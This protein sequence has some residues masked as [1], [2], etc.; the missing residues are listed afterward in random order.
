MTRADN[1]LQ[2]SL[3]WLHLRRHS[4]KGCGTGHLSLRSLDIQLSQARDP[5]HDMHAASAGLIV[6]YLVDKYG[7][8]RLAPE[9][10]SAQ[11]LQYTYWLHYSEGSAMTPILFALFARK[12]ATQSPWFLRPIMSFIS[13]TIMSS[14]VTGGESPASSVQPQILTPWLGLL[15]KAP[16]AWL[17]AECCM[18]FH[19]AG[20]VLVFWTCGKPDSAQPSFNDCAF[21]DCLDH[22]YHTNT[23]VISGV[24]TPH[25][26]CWL[27]EPQAG[28]QKVWYM[29]CS[30]LIRTTLHQDDEWGVC[31]RAEKAHAVPGEPFDQE[32]VVLGKRLLS[33]RHRDELPR[34]VVCFNGGGAVPQAAGFC[35]ALRG[36]ACIQEGSGERGSEIRHEII[37][38]WG[39]C[40]ASG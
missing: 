9:P 26:C 34:Q 6:E 18:K 23:Q 32:R 11:T 37:G 8:G 36:Y 30:M 40:G 21:L 10:G 31:C 19:E 38:V 27:L 1:A 20:T 17:Q 22:A 14:F 35:Q 4:C 16:C 13:G 2:L 5:N 12:I 33:S 3:A 28:F 7:N 39:V 24:V 25:F 29:A 15:A